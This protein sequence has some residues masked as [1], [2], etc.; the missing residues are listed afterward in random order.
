MSILRA[1]W[2]ILFVL[3]FKALK[4]HKSSQRFCLYIEIKLEKYIY[5]HR[6]LWNMCMTLCEI[7]QPRP[8]TTQGKSSFQSYRHKEEESKGSKR[9]TSFKIKL[10]HIGTDKASFNHTWPSSLACSSKQKRKYVYHFASQHLPVIIA[11]LIVTLSQCP[12]CLNTR[13]VP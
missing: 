3:F 10:V 2:L 9:I 12:F 5:F 4:Q 7:I 8:S 1:M 6:R 11:I 13:N